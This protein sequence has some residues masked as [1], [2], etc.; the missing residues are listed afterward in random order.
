MLTGTLASE[1]I[2]TEGDWRGVMPRFQDGNLERNLELVSSFKKLADKKGCTLAQLSIAW[3]LKQGD[4]VIPIPGTKKQKYLEGN[5]NSVHVHLT[6]SE[7][8]EIRAFVEAAQVAGD[9]GGLGLLV[10]TVNE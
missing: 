5:F 10:D 3:L 4:D 6:N 9:R 8:K 2:K 7:E 1:S